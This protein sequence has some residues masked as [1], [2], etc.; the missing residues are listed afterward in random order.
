M[1]HKV[2][3]GHFSRERYV[4]QQFSSQK[5]QEETNKAYNSH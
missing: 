4:L 2:E 1:G 5:N 3:L